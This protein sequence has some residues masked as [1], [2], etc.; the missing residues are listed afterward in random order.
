MPQAQPFRQRALFDALLDTL[1]PGAEL[2][3]EVIEISQVAE[4]R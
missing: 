3:N 4:K 2:V 1:Q